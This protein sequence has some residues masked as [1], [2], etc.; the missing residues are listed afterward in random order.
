MTSGSPIFVVIICLIASLTAYIIQKIEKPL[1]TTTSRNTTIDGLR[2]LLAL[3][4]FIHHSNLWNQFLT[5]GLWEKS[6]S[7]IYN[8]FGSIRVAMFFMITSFLFI[9]KLLN[10]KEGGFNFQHFL[11]SRA[12]RLMPMYLFSLVLIF[13]LIFSVSKWQLNTSIFEQLQ[14]IFYWSTFAA[15]KHPL[16]NNYPL[17]NLCTGA[18]WT[19][20][21]EWLFYFSMPLIALFLFKHTKPIY[22]LFGVM[23]LLLFLRFHTLVIYYIFEFIGGSLVAILFEYTKIKDKLKDSYGSVIWIICL[24]L[25]LRY[26]DARNMKCIILLTIM[27]GLV[28]AGTSLFGLFNV[29]QLHFIGKMSYSIY[30]LH[31]ILLFSVCYYGIGF[32]SFH[33]SLSDNSFCLLIF[34][35]TPLLITISY[36][37]YRFIERPFMDKSKSIQ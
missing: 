27:F 24:L 12:Y 5:E 8:Q 1:P 21:Y 2:G 3:G 18:L 31:S 11:I 6:K 15:F 29:K 19:M 33:T 32:S 16:I 28:A 9:S 23:F 30:L 37:G 14:S 26:N 20:A 36:L 4:V 17:T 13:I 22:K 7:N 35:L 10:D 34:F 25:F